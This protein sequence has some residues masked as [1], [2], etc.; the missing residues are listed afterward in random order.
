MDAFSFGNG[1]KQQSS[2]QRAIVH[3]IMAV[4]GTVESVYRCLKNIYGGAIGYRSTEDCWEIFVRFSEQ[5]NS[6]VH[7]QPHSGYPFSALI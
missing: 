2:K 7:D 4:E 5:G 1:I 3:F 6:T